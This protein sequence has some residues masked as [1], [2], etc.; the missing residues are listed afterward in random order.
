VL[1]LDL[2]ENRVKKIFLVLLII[3]SF[4]CADL[5]LCQEKI[6]EAASEVDL[7]LHYRSLQPGEVVRLSMR[8]NKPIR[9]AQVSFKGE[10]TVFAQTADPSKF[11]T[12]IG[13]DLG[14]EPG[15]YS[16]NF[17]ILYLD[18]NVEHVKKNIEVI[19]KK[20]PE[21]KLW[22]DEKFV[23]PPASVHERIRW[24]SEL[25]KTVYEMFTPRWLGE[26][27]FIIPSVG[28]ARP[29]FGERRVFNNKPRSSHS[30]VDISSPFGAPVNASNSGKVALAKDLYYAGNTVILDHGLGVFSLYC[31]FSQIKVET[32]DTVKKG[33]VIG[34]IGSTGRVTGP[35]LHWGMR[36]A[37][38]RVDPFSFLSLD[39]D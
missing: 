26:G 4:L 35:H 23:T 38:S 3:I 21:K 9:A 2:I 27:K 34:N 39:L 20:F 16:L 19:E 13:L 14:I 11:I 5:A 33:D 36:I 7:Q 6:E 1:K 37:G 24:E 15:Q 22:V 32:G 17:S 10:K 25:L 8:S 12:F 31:H 29:N 28:E 18:G 30:G